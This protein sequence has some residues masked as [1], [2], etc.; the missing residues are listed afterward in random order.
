MNVMDMMGCD[1]PPEFNA[2]VVSE[3]ARFKARG[4]I[5]GHQIH[6]M[7]PGPD[8]LYQTF[9]ENFPSFRSFTVSP[10]CAITKRPFL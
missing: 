9:G 8:I 10:L 3:K 5:S 1:A 4:R 7:H 6:H 2:S